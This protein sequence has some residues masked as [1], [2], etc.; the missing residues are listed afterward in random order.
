MLLTMEARAQASIG[1][2]RGAA[3]TLH[4]AEQLFDRRDVSTDP[5]W[6]S[7]FDHLELAGEAAHVFRDLGK[8]DETQRF[9]QLAIDPADTPPRTL[10]FIGLV[11]AA[12]KLAAGEVD[13]AVAT[14]TNAVNLAGALKS[15]RYLRYVT[16]FQASL[17]E[18]HATHA[19]VLG[20]ADTVQAIH[21]KLWVPGAARTPASQGI[22]R[23]E[24]F[25]SALDIRQQYPTTRQRSA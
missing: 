3:E 18:R 22:A 20:F 10:A 14:A 13:D 7:Y 9:V 23:R 25:A 17:L 8:P 24:E 6:I 12:G 2:E 5:E 19:S 21:P 1:D 15:S 4:R 11:S 16:D